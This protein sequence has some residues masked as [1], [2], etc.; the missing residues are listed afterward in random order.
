MD[1]FYD[2]CFDLDDDEE[3]EDD[4]SDDEDDDDDDVRLENLGDEDS[5][6]GES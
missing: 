4:V 5:G 3:D 6:N 2:D 1:D